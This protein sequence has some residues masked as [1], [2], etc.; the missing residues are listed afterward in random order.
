M[1]LASGYSQETISHNIGEMRSAGYPRAV[2]ARASYEE[3]RKEWRQRHP[4]KRFPKHLQRRKGSANRT[5]TKLAKR[6]FRQVHGGKE[7]VVV[8]GPY[9]SGKYRVNSITYSESGSW[10]GM[11]EIAEV[12]TPAEGA[13]IVKAYVPMG[14]VSGGVTRRGQEIPNEANARAC[15]SCGNYNCTHIK[16]S[17]GAKNV[18]FDAFLDAYI[19]TALWSS[20][21]E[22]DDRGGEPLDK[23]YGPSDLTKATRAK[24]KK[25]ASRFVYGDKGRSNAMAVFIEGNE[26][27]AGHDFW[28]TRNGH[29]AGF[30]DGD[31]PDPPATYLDKRSKEFGEQ[32][33]Y[34]HRRKIHVM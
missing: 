16:L 25:D 22:S 6:T 1:P 2:A 11:R 33:L 20:T 31:W 19:Q 30:W 4:G 14:Y 7:V 17:T 3:A 5:S 32:H 8:Q 28:L 9:Q 10:T 27:K 21:D 18:D 23:N 29:G 15:S 34:V 24:M 12:A 26:A 13:Q